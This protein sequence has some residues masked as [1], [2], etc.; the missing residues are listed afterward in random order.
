M[1]LET[2]ERNIYHSNSNL[3]TICQLMTVMPPVEDRRPVLCY[4]P[5]V[6]AVDSVLSPQDVVLFACP[7]D[8]EDDDVL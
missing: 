4:R 1:S 8:D 7:V 2:K 6:G 3:L 5:V